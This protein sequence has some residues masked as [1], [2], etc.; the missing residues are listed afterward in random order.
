MNLSQQSSVSRRKTW[1]PS[2][3]SKSVERRVRH[4]SRLDIPAFCKDLTDKN[5]A[6]FSNELDVDL[7]WAEWTEKFYNVLDKH[8]PE[9]TPRRTRRHR[10]CPWSSA[11][12]RHL[13]HI[14]TVTHRQLKKHPGN[15]VLRQQF[16]EA[17]KAA[18]KLSRTLKNKYFQEQCTT[19]SRHPRKFWQLINS[20]TGRVKIHPAPKASLTELS[21]QFSSVVSDPGRPP[22]LSVNIETPENLDRPSPGG[23]ANVSATEVCEHL[24]A[25]DCSKAPGSDNIP[26]SLL[27]SCASTLAP[28]LAKLFNSTI[29]TGQLPLQ[30]KKA[31]IAPVSKSGDKKNA[32]NYRPISLLPIVSKILE[33]LITHQL[34]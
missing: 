12:L 14:R 26:T 16:C 2:P 24:R 29:A 9:V 4:L 23:F 17:R 10:L 28:S 33:K 5:L 20:L 32:A 3:L 21:A 27:R 13:R 25:L 7:M 15:P 6:A 1:K 11:K 22:H 8:A 18:T 19:Y 31:T 34:K 30:F